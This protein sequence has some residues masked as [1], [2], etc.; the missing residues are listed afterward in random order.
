LGGNEKK[1]GLWTLVMVVFVAA[2]G[3][4]NV[5]SNLVYIGMAAIPSWILVAILYF[6]PLT[7]MIVELAGPTKKNLPASTAGWNADWEQN[8]LS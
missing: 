1:I 3:F 5:T 4:S 6:I 8:G 2:Y 7:I